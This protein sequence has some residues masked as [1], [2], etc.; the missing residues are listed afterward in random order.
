MVSDAQL[1][2][3]IEHLLSTLPKKDRLVLRMRFGIAV[4]EPMT[5]DEVSLRFDVTRER[6]RQIE[7]KAMRRVQHASRLDDLIHALG[8]DIPERRRKAAA[9]EE[10]GDKAGDD[11]ALVATPAEV[12][13]DAMPTAS[14]TRKR[15][16][17]SKPHGHRAST[18]GKLLD[19]V[20]AS[21]V[22]VHDDRE[23]ASKRVWV[24]LARPADGSSRTLVRKLSALGFEFWPGKGYWL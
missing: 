22:G 23:G 24:H 7:A 19:E 13:I 21:G 9:V 2:E 5:L 3:R 17:S 8:R 6:I 18:I 1:R 11:Q 15:F 16:S 10:Q 4:R 14:D 12:R 20:R